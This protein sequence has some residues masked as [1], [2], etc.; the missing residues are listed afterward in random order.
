MKKVDSRLKL[1]FQDSSLVELLVKVALMFESYRSVFF[2]KLNIGYNMKH[3]AIDFVRSDNSASRRNYECWG[4]P[5]FNYRDVFFNTICPAKNPRPGRP[6]AST[7]AIKIS[8][9][10][11]NSIRLKIR[12]F[13]ISADWIENL[14][15]LLSLIHY[16]YLKL[17]IDKKKI[18]KSVYLNRKTENPVR[19][20]EKTQKA[21]YGSQPLVL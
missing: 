6:R 15:T 10:H 20:R 4:N 8:L 3:I 17:Q 13:I 12:S 16:L 5:S 21:S 19:I 1:Q 11:S 7:S 9:V 2:S 18:I 14:L